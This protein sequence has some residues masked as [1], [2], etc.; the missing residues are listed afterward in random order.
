M[1]GEKATDHI[2]GRTRFPF[3]KNSPFFTPIGGNN[4]VEIRQTFIGYMASSGP[5]LA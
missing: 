1:T 4:G 2:L 5:E 3:V